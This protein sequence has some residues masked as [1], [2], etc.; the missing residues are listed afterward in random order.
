MMFRVS[1]T[2]STNLGG[3]IHRR[4]LIIMDHALL[5]SGHDL[6]IPIQIITH[7]HLVG[8]ATGKTLN[9]CALH[10]QVDLRSIMDPNTKEKA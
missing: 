7:I 5:T 8:K 2:T 9:Q 3:N 1:P 6:S 10:Y 4:S